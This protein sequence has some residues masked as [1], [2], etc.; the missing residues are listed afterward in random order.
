MIY[1]SPLFKLGKHEA[2]IMGEVGSKW[3]NLSPQRV[4]N[5]D[6]DPFHMFTDMNGVP[7]EII[8]INYILD[9]IPYDMNCTVPA[10]GKVSFNMEG[11]DTPQI[12]CQDG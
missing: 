8:Q 7:G 1:I 12:Y 11:Q 9:E 5:M 6:I 10:S 3:T 4:T 2:T